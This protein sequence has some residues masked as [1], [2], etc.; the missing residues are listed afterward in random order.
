M[1]TIKVIGG[2]S[3]MSAFLGSEVTERVLAACSVNVP[4]HPNAHI[5]FSFN[6]FVF[7]CAWPDRLLF[8]P[9]TPGLNVEKLVMIAPKVKKQA[10]SEPTEEEDDECRSFFAFKFFDAIVLPY[11]ILNKEQLSIYI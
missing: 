3:A 5:P 4:V 6:C 9:V 2:R 7:L 10:S 11:L 1:F 8:F